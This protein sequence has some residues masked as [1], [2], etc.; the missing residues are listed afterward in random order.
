MLSLVLLL[1]VI[2]TAYAQLKYN[3]VFYNDGACGK[4]IVTGD[5]W[6]PGTC[7]PII[8][9]VAPNSACATDTSKCDF[10]MLVSVGSKLIEDSPG[11]QVTFTGYL[12]TRALNYAACGTANIALAASNPVCATCS[13]ACVS[14]YTCPTACSDGT[15]KKL[16]S[17]DCNTAM[18]AGE[19]CNDVKPDCKSGTCSYGGATPFQQVL[20]VDTCAALSKTTCDATGICSIKVIGG[21]QAGAIVGIV[22]GVLALVVIGSVGYCYHKKVGPYAPE[23]SWMTFLKLSPAPAPAD[24]VAGQDPKA[25]VSVVFRNP[26]KTDT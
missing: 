3:I 26:T 7:Y 2:H 18:T 14:S 21:L 8:N 11:K 10:G 9:S 4:K 1:S 12:S 20:P 24:K 5:N 25:D 15:C 16:P 6:V 23:A 22:I 19:T 13:T 17:Y